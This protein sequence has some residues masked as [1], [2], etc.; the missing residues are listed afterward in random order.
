MP[1]ALVTGGAGFIGSSIARG[2]LQ[3]GWDVRIIDNFMAGFREH[4]PEQAE[5]LED[6]LRDLE[7]VRKATDGIEVVF[8]EAAIRSVPKSI[9]NPWLSHDCNVNGTVNLLMAAAD[10][11]VR[12][13]VYASS[14]SVYG[15]VKNPPNREDM[16][17]NPM[18][19]YAAS[20]LAAENYCRV[21]TH[22]R[23]LSSVS[24]RYFNVYGPGQHPESKYSAVF[25]G[26]ISALK[27]GRQP[28][29]HWDGEQSR[30]FSYIEDVV[31]ANIAAAEAD[32]RVDGEIF[33][34]GGGQPK[35]VN[36]VYRAVSDAMGV[37]VEPTYT[38]KR[39]G[40]VR[41]T[42]ADISKAR[43]LLGWEPKANWDEAVKA[44]VEW[45]NTEGADRDVGSDK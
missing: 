23:G 20:K 4:V 2:L 34:V 21:W 6:D 24:L 41:H 18:S 40:D 32:S 5:L 7:A 1:T 14:S 26:F 12:R 17:P 31:S 22:V 9:D 19:P 42:K 43:D 3:R 38:D 27:S 37:S 15:D 25:P 36:D 10:S 44:T 33:N 13:I 45:F 8:H 11:G 39:A 16:R 30:D 35:T 29:I 28:E